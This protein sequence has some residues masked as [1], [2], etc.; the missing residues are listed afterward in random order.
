M[1]WS[2]ITLGWILYAMMS[3]SHGNVLYI[4]LPFVRESTHH[5]C[6]FDVFFVISLNKLLNK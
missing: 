3:S 5:M 4:T 6:S 1:S 2:Y